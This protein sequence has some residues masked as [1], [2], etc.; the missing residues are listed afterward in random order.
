MFASNGIVFRPVEE[1]DLEAIRTLR[2]DPSTWEQLT[3]IGHISAEAQMAWFSRLDGDPS[4]EYLAVF[5]EKQDEHY[6]GYFEGDFVGIIR[7]D[8]IDRINRSVR[9][10]A[11]VVPA[12]RGKGYGTRIYKALLKY[13]FD[14]MGIHRT[15]LLVLDTNEVGKQ[16]YFNSGFKLEGKRRDAIWRNGRFIDYLAMSILENEYREMVK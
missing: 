10:G 1:N 13:C 7:M 11:D 15:W 2:N 4:R 6:P 3:T 9:I 12:M 5:T 16:L 14:Y 8:E